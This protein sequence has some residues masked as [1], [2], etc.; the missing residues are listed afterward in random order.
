[1]VASGL[2]HNYRGRA[3][4]ATVASVVYTTSV[5]I[6]RRQ[7]SQVAKKE[8]CNLLTGGGRPPHKKD[9]GFWVQPTVFT[10]V[11]PQHT[12][13]REEIFGPV[14]AAATF[15]TEEEAL[16]VANDSQ[17]GLGAAVISADMEV[18]MV[19]ICPYCLCIDLPMDIK[20]LEMLTAPLA[21]AAL[22]AR[23]V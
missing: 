21:S 9:G 17:F 13:W 8:G 16:A 1:M 6:P 3:I 5:E 18:C 7:P 20:T 2:Q 19:S 22:K 23:L 4:H 10:G 12:I 11:Q 15:S 14:L